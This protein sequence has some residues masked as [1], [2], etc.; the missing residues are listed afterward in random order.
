MRVTNDHR[1]L[2][3]SFRLLV[4]DHEKRCDA[5]GVPDAVHN[6]VGLVDLVVALVFHRIER[7]RRILPLHP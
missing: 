7:K 2:D 1:L 4:L 6:W 3:P 5:I